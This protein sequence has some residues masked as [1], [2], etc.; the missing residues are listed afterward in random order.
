MSFLRYR[1]NQ[2]GGDWVLKLRLQGTKNEIRWFIRLLQRD[3]RVELENTST[4]FSNKGT[5]RYKR[6]YTQVNRASTKNGGKKE[7]SKNPVKDSYCG[8]GK[9]FC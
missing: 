2:S 6:I 9:T 7:K 8:S 3:S 1:K 4:F 5:D